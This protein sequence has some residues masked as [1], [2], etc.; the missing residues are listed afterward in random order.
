MID[1]AVATTPF[2][3]IT[4]SGLDALPQPG[5]ERYAR[6]LH[7]SAGGG[8]ITAVGAARLGLRAALAGPL[9]SDGEGALLRDDLEREG[10]TLVAPHEGP[11]A[12][13]VVLPTNSDRAMV[14]YDPGARARAEDLAELAP[15]ALVC[16]LGELTLAP[17]GT[18][19]YLTLGDEEARALAGAAPASIGDAHAIVLNESEALRIT[20]ADDVTGAAAALARLGASVVVTRGRLGAV[21][22]VDGVAVSAAGVDAGPALDTTGA[23]DLFIAAYVWAELSGADPEERLRWAVLYAALSVTVPTAIAGAT[24]RD[25]LMEEGT[26]LGLPDPAPVASGD[27]QRRPK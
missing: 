13:T 21:G 18:S 20:G 22:V 26:R 14:T 4:F 19:V 7:R 11:T 6:Q 10:V 23:G 24:T 8:A 1:V 2:L 9:G 17:P 25:R 15:R 27:H 3:D 12:T 5:Q 16:G